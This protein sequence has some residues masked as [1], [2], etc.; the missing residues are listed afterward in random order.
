MK[1]VF[2]SFIIVIMAYIAQAQIGGL[3]A[4]KLN[5]LSATV[6]DVRKI[7]FEPSFSIVRDIHLVHTNVFLQDT[8]LLKSFNFRFTYGATPN[9]EFGFY[10]PVSM[11]DV[12]L[13]LKYLFLSKQKIFMS[14]IT[15]FNL[16]LD[17]VIGLN[18]YGAGLVTTLQYNKDLS[19][20]FQLAYV[21]NHQD[22]IHSGLFFNMDHGLYIGKIQYVIGLNSMIIPFDFEFS[23]V[24]ITPG[25]TIETGKQFIMVL[26]YNYSILKTDIRSQGVSF[27]L[28]I[29]LE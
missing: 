1:S 24:W 4:S 22:P 21:Q 25:V 16:S 5:T 3:S 19:S 10:M 6:V 15:G 28:T 18:N 27:A 11:S 8:S 9:L 12:A 14:F 26:S 29:T 20:D 13:G 7:E 17:S 2:I 23:Q